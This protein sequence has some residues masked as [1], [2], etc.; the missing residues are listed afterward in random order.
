MIPDQHREPCSLPWWSN[1]CKSKHGKE[2][3]SDT[4]QWSTAFFNF[5]F[6]LLITHTHTGP[7]SASWRKYHKCINI[8]FDLCAFFSP[9][10]LFTTQLPPVSLYF[11]TCFSISL[12]SQPHIIFISYFSEFLRI[13]LLSDLSTESMQHAYTTCTIDSWP[14]DIFWNA[15][16]Y[17][18]WMLFS[19]VLN[20]F[21]AEHRSSLSQ[22]PHLVCPVPVAQESVHS[23]LVSL[24]GVFPLPCSQKNLSASI[25]IVVLCAFPFS[26]STK[27]NFLSQSSDNIY[28]FKSVNNNR[29][30]PF[31]KQRGQI[32]KIKLFCLMGTSL[33][34]LVLQISFQP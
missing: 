10:S 13:H 17:A 32:D 15:A 23:S 12:Q 3:S 25:S 5:W 7:L 2:A 19:T 33:Y 29:N 30:I 24:G 31:Q 4:A 6:A 34:C 20:S 1:L 16:T 14:F 21:L 9:I 26:C 8:N 22:Q 18:V 11:L 28:A 27:S